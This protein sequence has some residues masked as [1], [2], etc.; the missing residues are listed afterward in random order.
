MENKPNFA[1]KAFIDKLNF[2]VYIVPAQ[3]IS[4]IGQA[5]SRCPTPARR[6]VKEV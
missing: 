2:A 4:T 3:A 6:C 5:P 1:I